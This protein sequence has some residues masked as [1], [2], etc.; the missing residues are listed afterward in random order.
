M[1]DPAFLAQPENSQ[2]EDTFW[3]D[4]RRERSIESRMGQSARRDSRT[5]L[6]E[7]VL[8]QLTGVSG[9]IL[10]NRSEEE[11]RQFWTAFFDEAKHLAEQEA[12]KSTTSTSRGAAA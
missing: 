9:E 2:A 12:A 11:D 4:F 8:N 7:R 1:T 6:S 3:D 5:R 10:P